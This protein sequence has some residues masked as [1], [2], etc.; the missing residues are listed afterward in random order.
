[1]ENKERP[2]LFVCCKRKQKME[3]CFPWLANDTCQ[4]MIAVSANVSICDYSLGNTFK[5]NVQQKLRW[6]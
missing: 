2:L 5:G 3:V 6:I 4:L 1:M